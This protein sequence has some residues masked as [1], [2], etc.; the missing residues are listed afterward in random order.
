MAL[1]PL[2][3]PGLPQK[4]P[5]SILPYRLLHLRIPR[6][7]DVSLRKT[8]SLLILGF[9]TGFVLWNFPL[10][11][12][13][14]INGPVLNS[15]QTYQKSNP[16]PYSQIV[17]CWSVL[18]ETSPRST[19]TLLGGDDVTFMANPQ[20]G[21]PGYPFSSLTC[22]ACENVLK[23]MKFT[24]VTSFPIYGFNLYMYSVMM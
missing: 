10:R 20:T 5:P 12:L 7:C 17:F 21:G 23:V 4:T 8:S 11:T 3:G 1:K 9:P 15:V 24:V 18:S 13:F 19:Q 2:L 14:G 22:P 16:F 6:I